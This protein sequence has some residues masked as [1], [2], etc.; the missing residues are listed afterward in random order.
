[1][2]HSY[3]GRMII[4]NAMIFLAVFVLILFCIIQGDL[5]YS[6][7]ET[8]TQM[9]Q[10]AQNAA[11]TIHENSLL[12]G[13]NTFFTKQFPEKATML[14]EEI[15]Q[16]SGLKTFLMDLQGNLLTDSDNIPNS[17]F[18]I[19]RQ[20]AENSH[21]P[22]IMIQKIR[23]I[24]KITCLSPLIIN[25]LVRGYV[26]FIAPYPSVDRNL[27]WI[28][29]LA[30]FLG[31]LFI[32][33][34]TKKF[35]KSFTQSIDDLT[36]IA[37]QINEGNYNASIYYK[38]DDEIGRLTNAFN[39]MI[40]NINAVV[41]QLEAE[42]KRLAGVLASLDDGLLALDGK[43]NVITANAT[44][45]TYFH[46]VNPK[47]IYDFQF[48]TFLKDIFE[49]LKNGKA[50]ISLEV[51]CDDRDL[52]II[53]S[54]MAEAGFEENYM[55]LIRNVTAANR[56]KKD[57]QQFISS[58]SHELRTPLTTIIGY[59]DMIL[60]R[61]LSDNPM[62]NHSLKTINN[63]GHRLLRL[64]D[65]LLSVNRLDTPEFSIKKM[66]LNLL[67]LINQVVEQ[68]KVK[69]LERDIDII[70]KTD[71]TL[72]EILG[73]YDRLQ[74]VLINVLHNAIKY[75]NKGDIIDVIAT[76]ENEWIT[77]SV[78]DYGVGMS[79]KE[80]ERV[81]SAFY[82]VEEDRARSEGEGGAGLGLYLVRQILLRH[83][84]DVTIES[85]PDEGT[86]VNIKLPAVHKVIQEGAH[87]E[88]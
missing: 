34:Q 12:S 30:G 50:H 63:E 69:S 23:G 71:E 16:Y 75:S 55:I 64:V 87:H 5:Y 21:R 74:Q 27:L 28:S 57:Q 8:E 25:D 39:Q 88:E 60:R 31:L 41:S 76:T 45:R 47:T 80:L 40:R 4:Y 19:Q 78:R 1:M 85:I 59:T 38:K 48:Q 82:R 29:I 3:R 53:G 7:K 2:K 9:G 32:M 54:P 33:Y 62:V 81:F 56:T 24:K 17:F 58:V 18:E 83:Q 79:E 86:K 51:D 70:V 73:D 46:V 15:E 77:I 68:M 14:S 22:I 6:V 36:D 49:E 26:G 44:I 72:P 84:G 61:E 11:L 42:R 65:D 66:T 35:S 10:A 13:R 37:L 52:M 67:P 20:G 43:G